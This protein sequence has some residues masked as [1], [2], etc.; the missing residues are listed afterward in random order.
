MIQDNLIA[1]P[2][3]SASADNAVATAWLPGSSGQ[4]R[5]CLGIYA[6]YSVAV[7]AIKTI[8]LKR[9]G[10]ANTG[11][12]TATVLSLGS[13]NQNVASTA[14]TFAQNG[15]AITSKGAVAAGTALAAG[16]IPIDTWGLYL[17][18]ITS[19]GTIVVTAAAANFTTG[20]ATEALAIA[21]LPTTPSTLPPVQNASMGYVTVKTKSGTTFVGGTDALATGTGGNVA[22]ATNYYPTS[23]IAPSTTVAVF[24][25]DFS[26]KLPFQIRCWGPFR[27]A[28]GE[29]LSV[30]LAASGA[31]STLGRV[32]LFAQTD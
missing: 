28:Q 10:T 8:T 29:G 23:A 4:T 3:Q 18:S 31:G 5:Y 19:A 20:Y 12:Y 6:D 15:G 26:S 7:A 27:G 24:N 14:F 2:I 22:S 9:G 30:E 32:T 25:H 11:P 13:T 17:F 21:A 1:E 16:T